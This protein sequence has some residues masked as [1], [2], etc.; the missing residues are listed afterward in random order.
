[1]HERRWRG[2]GEGA[3]E[4]NR[5]VVGGGSKR[6]FTCVRPCLVRKTS[7]T[8]APPRAH[9]HVPWHTHTHTYLW[10]VC[11]YIHMH[12]HIHMY[13]YVY[14]YLY[15]YVYICAYIFTHICVYIYGYASAYICVYARIHV[16]HK[17]I[18]RHTNTYE[19]T[20]VYYNLRISKRVW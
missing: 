10:Y 6:V 13:V 11:I 15:I 16:Y 2:V 3:G 8:P 17:D 20:H 12:V 18:S 5:L 1:M 4:K 19:Y 9:T 14:T 7:E